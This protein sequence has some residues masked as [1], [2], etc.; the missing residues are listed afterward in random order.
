M[1]RCG[2]LSYGWLVGVAERQVEH[3]ALVGGATVEQRA[4]G[5]RGPGAVEP[6]AAPARVE[7]DVEVH[8]DVL[9]AIEFIGHLEVADALEQRF[10][11]PCHL[12][13]EGHVLRVRDKSRAEDER[14]RLVGRDRIARVQREPAPAAFQ[15]ASDRGPRP[16]AHRCLRGVADEQVGAEDPR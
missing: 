7:Q 2:G 11:R 14:H 12:D 3:A 16:V 13:R 1:G 9:H 5:L 10:F 8:G 6:V 15:E 4:I